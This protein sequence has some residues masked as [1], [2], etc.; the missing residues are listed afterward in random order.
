MRKIV[1]LPLTIGVA[2]A[3]VG[4]GGGTTTVIKERTITEATSTPSTS[5]TETDT[6]TATITTTA[7]A[8]TTAPVPSEPPTTIVHDDLFQS[9]SG[10][11]GCAMVGGVARCDIG[12]RDWSPPPRPSSCSD[13]TDYGQGLEVSRSGPADVV[14]A[15][16][17]TR[18]PS[19]PKLPYGTGSQVGDF[20]CVSRP[21]GITCTD[22]FNGH[23][24]FVSIQA[25]KLF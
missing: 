20:I 11:I 22:R 12:Q 19:A 3:L 13:V 10:N 25:Y 21:T 4:C 18:D 6:S 8:D 5:T 23:G 7:T 9:P 15:G 14:C 2:V 1:G 16:D 24:F 17:T